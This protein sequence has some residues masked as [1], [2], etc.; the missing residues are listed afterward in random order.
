MMSLKTIIFLVQGDHIKTNLLKLK[1]I[2]EIEKLILGYV[3]P[4]AFL[5]PRKY[6]YPLNW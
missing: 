1:P 6:F 5:L 3:Q 2:F 4:T